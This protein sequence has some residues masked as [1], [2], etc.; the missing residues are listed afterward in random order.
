MSRLRRQRSSGSHICPNCRHYGRVGGNR[1]IRG[2][3]AKFCRQETEIFMNRIIL[4]DNQAI[5]RA[6]AARTLALEDDM[7]I[8]AQCEDA[9]KL[10]GAID[11]FR[12]SVVMV[13]TSLRMDWKD[14]VARTRSA[15]S[16]IILVAE[17]AEQIAD[18]VVALVD[19]ILCRSVPGRGPGGLRAP[20]GAG[21][22]LCAAVER[23][24]DAGGGQR[25]DARSRP[26]YTEGDAD[27]RAD[28]SGMQEQRHRG[29]AWDEGAGN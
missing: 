26:A 8:V 28:R 29:A 27:R 21:K 25:R 11:T 14:L 19:G 17:N 16:R 2:L 1:P 15:G 7:R 12:G 10:L 4:A 6:G 18:D 24:D 23:D 5:F 20:R 13:A 22:P 9:A 3:R